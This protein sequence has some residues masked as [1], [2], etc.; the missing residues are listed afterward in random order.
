MMHCTKNV[1][2]MI[3]IPLAWGCRGGNIMQG[4]GIGM[5]LMEKNLITRQGL[6]I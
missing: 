6:E 5:D 2:I 1:S 3:T 4:V